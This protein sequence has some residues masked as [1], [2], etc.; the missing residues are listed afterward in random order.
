MLHIHRLITRQYLSFLLAMA[1]V[2]LLF[3][4]SSRGTEQLV[5]SSRWLE[6]SYAVLNQI[7]RLSNHVELVE[8]ARRGYL[9]TRHEQYL[10]PYHYALEQVQN[11]MQDLRMLV[12]DNPRQLARVN[13]VVPGTE[14]LIQVAQRTIEQKSLNP[15]ELAGLMAT[16]KS[17]IDDFR[18]HMSEMRNEENGLLAKRTA[19]SAYKTR[20]LKFWLSVTGAAFVLLLVYSFFG[21]SREVAQRRTVEEGLREAQAINEITVHNLSLMSEM[22][23]MLQACANVGEALE[24][25]RQFMGQLVN[26]DAGAIYLFRE[27]RN[28]IE[29]VSQWGTATHS[30]S[31]FGPD[32]CW[33]LRRGAPHLLDCSQHRLA[34]KHVEVPTDISAL[35]MPIVAQ[36]NVLG[37]LYLEN[38]QRRDVGESERQLAEALASQ[39]ALALASIKLRDTLSNLSVRDPLTGLFNRR[40]MEE[41]LQREIAVAERQQL[42][43]SVAILDLDHF[44]RF[45][46]TFGH[47]AGDLLL[48]KVANLLS[49]KSR[50]GDIACRFGGE[51]FVIIYPGATLES[52]L[53]RSNELREEILALQLQHFGRSLGQVSASFG[54]AGFP[55]HGNA[56]E[57]LLRSADHALYRA[58]EAGRNRV[59]IAM[60]ENV[61]DPIPPITPT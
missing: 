45:N 41:S 32:D 51:E 8:T 54:L 10:R 25:I 61:P 57:E 42:P 22:T 20:N 53:S 35:C 2:P 16:A 19:D 59:E 31:I 23:G 17:L 60:L 11:D 58:K 52:A 47:E 30:A 34:C 13:D 4:L 49:A 6:H 27:S 55:Q 48:R 7:E 37:I 21:M 44:K 3:G 24:V 46:D 40:Y 43:L 5:Q 18:S 15:E 50:S 9:L 1:I 33:A 38:R 12:K 56:G 36:G 29:S 14:A 39:I 28:Q 26:V